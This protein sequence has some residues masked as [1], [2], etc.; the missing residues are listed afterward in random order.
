MALTYDLAREPDLQAFLKQRPGAPPTVELLIKGAR[1]AACLGQIA[2]EPAA[3]P[4]VR[5]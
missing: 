1:C 3:L 2:R 5:D 4:G